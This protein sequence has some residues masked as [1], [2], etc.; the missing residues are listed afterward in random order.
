MNK[1]ISFLSAIVL[2]NSA[3]ASNTTGTQKATATLS[4]TCSIS[5]DDANFGDIT[6][7]NKSN[8]TTVSVPLKVLCSNNV[9]YRIYQGIGTYGN[10]NAGRAMKGATKGDY[11]WYFL[12]KSGSLNA[13]ATQCISTWFNSDYVAGIGN[14]AIQSVPVYFMVWGSYATPD[15]YADQTTTTISF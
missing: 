7:P 4:S 14:G 13:G 6:S 8:V 5:S 15:N 3:I 11:V 2:I 1:I 12:C 10:V 9:A